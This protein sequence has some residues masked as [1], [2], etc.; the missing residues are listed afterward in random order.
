MFGSRNPRP[1]PSQQPS[2]GSYNRIPPGSQDRY[3]GAPPYDSSQ[4]YG[5]RQQEPARNSGGGRSGHGG[6]TWQ[7]KPAKAPP[8]LIYGNVVAVSPF[9]FQ[10]SRDGG[11]FY[12]LINDMY[13]L[14]ARPLDGFQPGQLSLSDPQRTWAAISLMD[15][16][17]V[18][19]YD[20]FQEGGHRY[21]GSL[22]AEISF[23]GKKGTETPL[24]Q[25]EL[26]QNFTK[27]FENQIFAPGQRV[28][29][30]FRSIPLLIV[31]RTVQLVDL[32]SE[33]PTTEPT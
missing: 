28:I 14:S 24:D 30:D 11:D 23:A 10:P 4:D 8:Q 21:L 7:L 17:N 19:L 3:G 22:D 33:K 5:R 6:Q 15:T 16:V 27:V 26:A 13:V 9:D 29:M 1:Q 32:T 12:I 25:D 31:V 2:S 18:K 20:P